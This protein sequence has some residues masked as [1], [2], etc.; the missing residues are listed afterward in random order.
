MVGCSSVGSDGGASSETDGLTEGTGSASTTPSTG[1]G[2]T[3]DVTGQPT[4]ATGEGPTSDVTSDG[5]TSEVTGNP[6]TDPTTGDPSATATSGSTT[7]D[8]TT[9]EPAGGCGKDPGFRGDMALKITVADVERDYI[10]VVPPGYDPNKSYPL[11]FAWHGRGS[12]GAQ[13][14]LY[15]KVEEASKGEAIFIYPYGLPLADMQDQTGWDLDPANEDFAL[16]DAL[17]A[18][19][20]NNLCVDPSRVFST[21][22]SFGAYMS[23][24]L[25]C[26]RADVL[27]GIGE[28]AGGGPFGQCTGQVAAWMAHGTLDAVVPYTEGEKARDFTTANNNCDAKADPVDPAPCTAFAGCD[29]GVPVHWCSHD[30]AEFMGHTW[31]SWAGDG[32][33]DFFAAL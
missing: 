21:G 16:F 5:P 8:D 20:L 27:R 6:T 31:P 26:Y 25:A 30:I 13:A 24:Q 17:L 10:L 14:R 29:D 32:I 3:S 22:H 23:I 18:D 4:T 15:F 33:W 19:A 11:V 7:S 2:P 9:G 28:V 1:E 12:N